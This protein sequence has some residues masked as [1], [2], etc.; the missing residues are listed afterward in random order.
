MNR[1]LLLLLLLCVH[2]LQAAIEEYGFDSSEDEQRFKQLTYEL[3]CPKCLN[4]NLAGSDAP[5]A[6]DLRREIYNQVQEGHSNDEIVA[7]MSSRYG[8]FIRYRPRLTAATFILWFGPALLLIAGFLIARR[9][10]LASQG[11]PEAGALSG[12]EQ[13]KLRRILG[14]KGD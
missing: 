11:Q 4:S 7:F 3:R 10:M 14:G 8:D 6:A 2:P 1:L 12:A 9:M 13:D 5:I